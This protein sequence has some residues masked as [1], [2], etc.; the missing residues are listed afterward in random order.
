MKLVEFFFCLMIVRIF[1]CNSWLAMESQITLFPAI[2]FFFIIYLYDVSYFGIYFFGLVFILF[3][4]N[5]F[6]KYIDFFICMAH[7]F[8][9]IRKLLIDFLGFWSDIGSRYMWLAAFSLGWKDAKRDRLSM[10]K[11]LFQAEKLTFFY[12][13]MPFFRQNDLFTRQNVLLELKLRTWHEW[14]AS[15]NGNPHSNSIHLTEI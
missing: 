15:L 1:K 9:T 7:I 11:C 5:S 8:G 13:F 6:T 12:E 3:E 10:A 14:V 4:M 2:F